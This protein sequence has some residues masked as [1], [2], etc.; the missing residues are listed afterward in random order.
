MS[1]ARKKSR[2]KKKKSRKKGKSRSRSRG[3]KFY[4]HIY[5]EAKVPKT[6]DSVYEAVHDVGTPGVNSPKEVK[7]IAAAQLAD[8]ADKKTRDHHG[9]K[10]PFTSRTWQGRML[11]LRRLSKKVGGK[12]AVEVVDKY[13]KAALKAPSKAERLA[14]IKQGLKKLGLKPKQIKVLIKK[15]NE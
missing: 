7:L 9:E 1:M 2:K 12:R 14:V 5:F 15:T 6:R 8:L 13:G 11:V 10:I 4:K 3:K